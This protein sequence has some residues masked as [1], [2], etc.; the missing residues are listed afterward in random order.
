[1]TKILVDEIQA[2]GGK[3]FKVSKDG[4]VLGGAGIVEVNA[5]PDSSTSG[6]VGDQV[7]FGSDIYRH[8]EENADGHLWKGITTNYNSQIPPIGEEIF[9]ESGVFVVTPGVTL[10]SVVAVGAGGGGAYTWANSAAQGGGLAWAS[11]VPVTS[12]QTIDITISGSSTT[13]SGRTP[14]NTNGGDSVVDGIVTAQGGNYGSN[15]R[16]GYTI[17]TSAPGVTSGGG[18]GGNQCCDNWQGGGGGA[19]GYTGDGGNGVYGT[20]GAGSGGG[21]GGG[22]GYPSSTYG[23][24]GGGGVGIFGEGPSGAGGTYPHSN[25]WDSFPSNYSAG[26]G[27]SGGKDGIGQTNSSHSGRDIT[28]PDGKVFGESI[29][30]HGWG[31]MYGGGGGGAGSSVSN[32]NFGMGGAGVV[33]I[34]WGEGRSFPANAGYVKPVG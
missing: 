17:H 13:Y 14:P 18:N 31:G 10:I 12:G 25:A 6:S 2:P 20:G 28:W 26:K 11:F 4:G 22:G 29:Q 15:S 21:G 5:L 27:G 32:G 30:Y 33:R 8:I 16:G 34:I 1:M 23:F 3:P 7:L 19:G 9:H 24:G